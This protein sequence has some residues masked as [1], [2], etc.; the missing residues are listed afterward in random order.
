MHHLH[1]KTN[2]DIYIYNL[3]GMASGQIKYSVNFDITSIYDITY[4]VI[5]P[6]DLYID[7]PVGWSIFMLFSMIGSLTKVKS[8]GC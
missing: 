4:K 2:I 8:M 3:L 5:S 1:L 7:L 6:T